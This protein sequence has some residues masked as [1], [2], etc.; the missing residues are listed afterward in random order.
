MGLLFDHGCDAMI[1]FI[2]GITL[3]T[4]L[5]FGNNYLGYL[6]Y[7]S[8]AIPFYITTLEEVN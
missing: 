5:G 6:V 3:A 4:C 8:G 1:V 2:Q 7:A